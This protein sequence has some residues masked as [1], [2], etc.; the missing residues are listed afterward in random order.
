[1]P[2]RG[3][4][5]DGVFAAALPKRCDFAS[6]ARIQAGETITGVASEPDVESCHIS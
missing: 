1:M 2:F 3:D 4:Y 6:D 5:A